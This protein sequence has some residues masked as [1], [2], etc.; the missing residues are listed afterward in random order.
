M[1]ETAGSEVGDQRNEPTHVTYDE[2]LQPA[3]PRRQE[4][5]LV[6]DLHG[7]AVEMAPHQSMSLLVQASPRP[8]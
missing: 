5:A 7:F 8:V 4:F 1:S 2:Y 6:D 3:R